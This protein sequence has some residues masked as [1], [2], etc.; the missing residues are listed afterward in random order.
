MFFFPILS[1][2]ID[3]TD[4]PALFPCGLASKESACYY[5]GDLGMISGLENSMEKG[6][7]THSSTPGLRI[8][9]DCIGHGVENQT[10]LRDFHFHACLIELVGECTS[11]SII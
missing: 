9:T 11:F 4:K 1:F 5:T 10:Q 3:I 8:S 2:G 6:K 7:A